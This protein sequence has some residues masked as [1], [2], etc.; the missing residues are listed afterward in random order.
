MKP[1]IWWFTKI[2]LRCRWS[3]TSL[4]RACQRILYGQISWKMR[5]KEYL[6]VLGAIPTFLNQ[7]ACFQHLRGKRKF[8][9]KKNK[10]SLNRSTRLPRISNS[11]VRNKGIIKEAGIIA[12]RVGRNHPESRITAI[13]TALSVYLELQTRCLNFPRTIQLHYQ[14]DRIEFH[15]SFIQATRKRTPRTKGRCSA[16]QWPRISL[17]STVSW[18]AP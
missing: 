13:K 14:I 15:Q 6:G 4:K 5:V 2:D 1:R 8:R 16:K 3:A 10:Y 11:R 9:V 18:E 7:G 12:K 17:P